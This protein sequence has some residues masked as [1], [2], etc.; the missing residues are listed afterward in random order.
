M[1]DK[2]LEERYAEGHTP[3]HIQYKKFNALADFIT[4][5]DKLLEISCEIGT[6][7]F[8][9]KDKFNSLTG[10]DINSQA[11]EWAKHKYSNISNMEFI[12]CKA[13]ELPFT[14]EQFDYI[15]CLDALEHYDYPQIILRQVYKLLTPDGKFIVTVPNWYDFFR[16]NPKHLHKHIPLGWMKLM[17]EAGFKIEKRW[18]IDFPLIHSKLLAK[19][20]YWLGGCIVFVNSK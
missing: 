1:K 8:K 9:L 14:S 12:T 2:S 17:E 7:M 15:I 19:Y 3:N 4:Q 16:K 11:I 6:M 5:G 13:E 18:A 20:L 10:I